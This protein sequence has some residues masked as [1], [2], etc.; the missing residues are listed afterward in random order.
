VKSRDFGRLRTHLWPD[1]HAGHL[2]LGNGEAV[3]TE[4]DGFTTVPVRVEG[5]P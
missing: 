4:V 5:Q 2:L 1:G 3:R